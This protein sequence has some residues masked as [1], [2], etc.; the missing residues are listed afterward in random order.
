MNRNI[1]VI[2]DTHFGHT[3][4]IDYCNRPFES[5]R[6]MDE[7]IV[8]N[9]NATVGEKDIVYHLGDV[10]FGTEGQKALPKLNGRKRLILGNHDSGKD[11]VLLRTFQKIMV[12]RMFPEFGLLLTHVPVHEKTLAENPKRSKM[13]NVH[14]HIHNQNAYSSNY[15]N[16]S[17]EQIEYTP[18]N[19]ELLSIR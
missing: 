4:I 11:Q 13:I 3:N 10:Y 18:I 8:E 14:G 1:W 2:S 7:K 19:I 9:W 12:W 6:E 5:A 16:V 17:V 15:F